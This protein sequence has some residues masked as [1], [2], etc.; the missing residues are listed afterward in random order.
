MCKFFNGRKERGEREREREREIYIYIYNKKRGG[1]DNEEMGGANRAHP[2]IPVGNAVRSSSFEMVPSASD[3]AASERGLSESMETVPI[4]RSSSSPSITQ[5]PSHKE[6]KFHGQL[7]TPTPP[8]FANFDPFSSVVLGPNDL[9][10]PYRAILRSLRFQGVCACVQERERETEREREREREN[11]Q[12]QRGKRKRV[13]DPTL[14]A[15]S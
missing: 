1:G 10:A 2:Y 15:K 9:A 4:L 7:C 12:K 3:R 8:E 6:S 11:K 14:T 13:P 5:N